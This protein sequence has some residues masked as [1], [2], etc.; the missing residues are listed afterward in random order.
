M[1]VVHL[2]LGFARAA[3]AS[4][5]LDRIPVLTRL[6]EETARLPGVRVTALCRFDRDEDLRRSGVD[7]HF[8]V[9]DP[10]H[11]LAG[12]RTFPTALFGLA[13]DLRPDVVHLHGLLFPVQAAA[14]RLWLGRGPI[15]AVQHHGE[16]PEG[17]M[18]PSLQR[19][20]FR[21]ADG[22]LFTSPRIAHEWIRA[23]VLDR[24]WPIHG[25]VEAST[26]FVPV[27]SAEARARTGLKGSPSI[28]WV[29]RLHDKKDP[30]TA[31]EGFAGA[32]EQL[33]GAHLSMVYREAPL[34]ADVQA[35]RSRSP[36]LAERVHLLA[37][38]PHADLPSHYS[39]ADLFLTSSPAEGSNFA[40]L[41]ALAC[42]TPPVA[43]DIP[44]HRVLTG[45]GAV[46]RLFTVGD[47][48]SC[49]RELVAAATRLSEAARLAARTHFEESLGWP[50]VVAQA[51]KAYRSLA[52]G[53]GRGG[54]IA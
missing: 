39:A 46:G 9:D 50:A 26:D 29:G 1:H 34:L 11:L 19:L 48:G 38:V 16:R 45:E 2:S 18:R 17:R 36:L 5:F 25:V 47:A 41:E 32:L 6:C 3:D 13:R 22:F 51:G 31:L 49:A 53:K 27:P 44:A 15:L 40:L 28:L 43:S 8:R 14:L 33:P 7:Y 42:G 54:G 10:R 24:G 37:E 35:F 21:A 4:S 52:A 20:L 30:M 12:R 23:G